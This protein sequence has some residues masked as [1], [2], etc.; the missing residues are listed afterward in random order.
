MPQSVP[1][2]LRTSARSQI[3]PFAL[4]L[5]APKKKCFA[6]VG[7]SSEHS[8]GSCLGTFLSLDQS[9]GKG[10]NMSNKNTWQAA[11]VWW[12]SSSHSKHTKECWVA[13]QSHV[14]GSD[15]PKTP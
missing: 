13:L 2:S 5:L 14:L 3:L 9:L 7:S 15:P 4:F 10:K 12:L 1:S 6:L 8:Q 11:E